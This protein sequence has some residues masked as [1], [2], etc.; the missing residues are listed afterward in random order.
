MDTL[1]SQ[2]M[3]SSSP[4]LLFVDDRIVGRISSSARLKAKKEDS[5]SI[6]RAI[7]QVDEILNL[8][9]A[10]GGDDGSLSTDIVTTT[11]ESL[12]IACCDRSSHDRVSS[13]TE[14]LLERLEG[15][16]WRLG[17]LGIA[18]STTVFEC[19]W[20]LQQSHREIHDPAGDVDEDCYHDG[21]NPS[22]VKSSRHVGRSVH[23]LKEWL[24]CG[25]S[26]GGRSILTPVPESYF[27]EVL[28]FAI[29]H[30]VT[31]SYSIWDLY[32][33]FHESHDDRAHRLPRP[34][35]A[36][37]L[38]LLAT[39]AAEWK[40]RECRV[41]QDMMVQARKYNSS[42]YEP[43]IS[44]IESVLAHSIQSGRV[45]DVAWLMRLL[46][47]P[48]VDHKLLFLQA[49]SRSREDGSILYMERL[50]EA[51]SDEV[52][53]DGYKLLLRKLSGSR[54]PGRC[55][56]ARRAFDV[57]QRRYH[58]SRQDSEVNDYG[59]TS[60]KPDA[61]CVY[62]VVQ[63]YLNDSGE[64]RPSRVKMADQFLRSCVQ[65]GY[66]QE[67]SCSIARDSQKRYPF[68]VF[69][70]MLEFYSTNLYA[71]IEAHEAAD[72]LYQFFLVQHRNGM[73]EEQP[74]SFHLGHIL[75]LWNLE[76]IGSMGVHKSLEYLYL[77]DALRS[78]GL[79]Q[80]EPDEFNIRQVLG[81]MARSDCQGMGSDASQLLERVLR[82]DEIMSDS[83]ALGHMFWCAIKCWCNDG[84]L[85]G[86]VRAI[87]VLDRLEALFERDSSMVQVTGASYQ[88][89]LRT[90]ATILKNETPKDPSVA[91]SVEAE[92][93]AIAELAREVVRRIELQNHRGN[94]RARL[95]RT[96]YLDAIRCCKTLPAHE[97]QCRSYR[98]K[99]SNL[100]S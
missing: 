82:K 48:S 19:L 57:I 50:V 15:V 17:D 41:L 25:Q 94:R 68:R 32:R 72:Q 91:A 29:E 71:D 53:L 67:K 47:D 40:V 21:R 20:R 9:N 95:T 49:L 98:E 77:F 36:R 61:H 88:T 66:M 84:T 35:Y 12:L 22:G 90:L 59:K 87:E 43:T 13:I 6:N 44:E 75:R 97:H 58:Q 70:K 78:R 69:D 64:T 83:Y 73:I 1:L 7:E 30:S 55:K 52:G 60:W 3:Q 99:L 65:Q 80:V 81:T 74:D 46:P 92:K 14:E 79:I 42:E 31:M 11:V 39:S 16:V 100:K 89:V 51:W 5:R 4:T 85:Q 10:T 93:V 37:L 24:R 23:L 26:A 76:S 2:R 86:V 27:I 54:A 18:P 45:Q 8:Y 28:D 56:R 63:S 34:V 38:D 33:S 96:I 62:M